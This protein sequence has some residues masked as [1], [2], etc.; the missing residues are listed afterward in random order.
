[1]LQRVIGEHIR[2]SFE[3]EG[4]LAP[5]HG[6]RGMIEQVL[7][8]L[9]LNARD[10]MPGGGELTVRTETVVL[11]DDRAHGLGDARPGLHVLLSVTDT[12]TGMAPEVLERVWEP[13]FTTKTTGQGT[14]LGLSQVY[15]IVKQHEGAVQVQSEVGQGTTVLAYFPA[16]DRAI[17]AARVPAPRVPAGG[18]SETILVVEDEDAVRALTRR[19]LAD[20]GYT[21]LT[22]CDGV[23][24]L[25]VAREYQGTIDLALLDVVMPRLGG[26]ETAE[27]LVQDR[28]GIRLLFATGYSTDSVHTDFVLD[29]GIA[30]LHKPFAHDDLLHKLRDVLDADA[31]R[32][33]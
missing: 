14:G 32:T 17:E 11:N 1:M 7:L 31:P 9:C 26:R 18:G 30:L 21:V 2:L 20:A 29:D 24:A 19:V 27:Q 22:A 6:D 8:N 16:V 13:F 3:S 15:G 23:D 12:G 33:D 10:A 28:P 25:G 4:D 5:V